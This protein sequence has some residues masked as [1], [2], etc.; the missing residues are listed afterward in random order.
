MSSRQETWRILSHKARR[1]NRLL[2]EGESL[3]DFVLKLNG[4][5][6]SACIKK[7]VD[8]TKCKAHASFLTEYTSYSSI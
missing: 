4:E 3:E 7:E 8:L 1:K 2:N 6:P 5:N